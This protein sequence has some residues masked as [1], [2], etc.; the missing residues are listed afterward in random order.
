MYE[1]QRVPAN[2]KRR[3]QPRVFGEAGTPR[4]VLADQIEAPDSPTYPVHVYKMALISQGI[5]D[6]T[7]TE[8]IG[9]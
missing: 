6:V 9:C 7:G 8:R 1:P 3:T 2:T 4:C 5:L